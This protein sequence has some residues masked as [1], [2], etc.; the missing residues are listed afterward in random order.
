MAGKVPLW[1]AVDCSGG[2]GTNID[3]TTAGTFNPAYSTRSIKMA[4]GQE[5]KMGPWSLSGSFYA[6]S[7]DMK[8]T[9]YN[10]AGDLLIL[11]DQAAQAFF[12]LVLDNNVISMEYSH[13]NFVTAGV[14]LVN[15]TTITGTLSSYTLRINMGTN[16][17]AL[18]VNDVAVLSNTFNMAAHTDVTAADFYSANKVDIWFSKILCDNED[19]LTRHP[20]DLRLTGIG[21]VADFT[22][23][24]TNLTD[25]NDATF[26]EV[27]NLNNIG[28][29]THAPVT[30]PENYAISA[31]CST[32]RFMHTGTS[33]TDL[34]L[35]VRLN[36]VNY[37]TAFTH[38]NP[39]I[40]TLTV[41]FGGFAANPASASGWTENEANAAQ[42]GFK[43]VL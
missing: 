36:S 29:F 9:A 33:I 8:Y 13:D 5:Y 19:T 7:F 25:N 37:T 10:I 30:V 20:Y 38:K 23:P 12:R 3:A 32:V 2:Y 1:A 18:L 39:V 41:G 16:D 31:I 21:A 6:M 14:S 26:M 40:D 4:A 24:Y 15:T 22:G 35:V 28:T 42:V 17:I 34:D 27:L 43:G 11:Y